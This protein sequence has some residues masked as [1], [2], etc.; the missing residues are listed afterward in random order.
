[1]PMTR[2][3]QNKHNKV[4]ARIVNSRYADRFRGIIKHWPE[5]VLAI[6]HY[7]R[8]LSLRIKRK[9]VLLVEPNAFHGVVLPGACKYFQDLGYEVVLLCRLANH[10]EGVFCRCDVK[11]RVFVLAPM[12]MRWALNTRNVKR[13]DFVFFTSN[14]FFDQGVRHWGEYIGYLKFKPQSR[15]GLLSIEHSFTL[16]R[17]STSTDIRNLFSLTPRTYNGTT[18]PMLNTHYFG[19]VKQTP[20]NQGKRVFIFV[21]AVSVKKGSISMLIDN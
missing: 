12:L 16:D 11:P 3:R 7:V 15:L 10:R 13:F 9:T 21:G 4:M 2:K 18:V 14:Q 19:D 5:V 20:L 6:V 17:P 1:M 8:F